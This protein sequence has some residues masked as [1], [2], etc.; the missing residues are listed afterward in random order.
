MKIGIAILLSLNL[1]L[2]A[3]TFNVMKF[4]ATGDGKTLDTKAIQETIDTASTYGGGT[5]LIP[6]GKFLTGPFTLANNVDLHL[7]SN[8]VIL[9]DNDMTHYPVANN[10]YQ[11]AITAKGAHDIKITGEGTIDGQGEAWWKAF[12]ANPKMTHRPYL[13]KLTD[14]TRVTITG[15]TLQ[16]SP[17]FHLVPQNCTDVTIQGITIHSPEDAPNTD[18]I[19]PSGWNVLI[20]DCHI[21]TGDDNIAIKPVRDGRTPGNKNFI[22]KNC[23]FVHGHGMS[24]GGGTAGGLED[25]TVSDCTFDQTDRAIRIKTLRGNG[26]SLR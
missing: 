2:L 25:L 14:C 22:V 26:G 15:V 23:T 16:N 20:A 6:A 24:I 8:A 21:D 11:D 3:G 9:I 17:M 1:P 10:R 12:R 19:D 13:I 5:V 7:E 18:G 4:G